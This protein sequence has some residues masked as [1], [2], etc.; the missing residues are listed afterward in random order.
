MM[1][2]ITMKLFIYPVYYDKIQNICFFLKKPIF[3][4]SFMKEVKMSFFSN[5]KQNVDFKLKYVPFSKV[6]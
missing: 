5:T 1:M 2:T 6:L 3:W 4:D